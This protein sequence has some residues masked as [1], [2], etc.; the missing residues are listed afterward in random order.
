[1][2]A[3]L[4]S[5][6]ELINELDFLLGN[7][8]RL[9][10]AERGFLVSCSKFLDR[11]YRVNKYMMAVRPNLYPKQQKFL[12]LSDLEVY[13]GGSTGGGKS[14]S[15][16]LASLQFADVPTYSAVVLRST[17]KNLNR[18]GSIMDRCRDWLRD[19]DAHWDGNDYRFT[20]PSGAK[21]GFAYMES[22]KHADQHRSAEYQYCVER[23]SLVQMADGSLSPIESIAVGDMVRTL[24]GPQRV[25]HTFGPMVK[26]CVAVSDH[27]GSVVQVQ[28][29]SHR[30]LCDGGGWTSYLDS[31]DFAPDQPD[32]SSPTQCRAV[33]AVSSQTSRSCAETSRTRGTQ[34]QDQPQ[35]RESFGEPR[36]HSD[37]TVLAACGGDA[38]SVSVASRGSRQ[39]PPPQAESSPTPSRSSEHC[40]SPSVSCGR[41]LSRGA[42]CV[43]NSSSLAGCQEDCSADSCL[44]GEQPHRIAGSDRGQ[45]QQPVDVAKRTLT[46]LP[47]DA[48]GDVPAHSQSRSSVYAHPYTMVG[49]LAC[50]DVAAYPFELTPCGDREV[51]DIRV[52][53][54]SHYITECG[55]VNSNCGFDEVTEIPEECYRF[56]FSRMRRVKGGPGIPLRVRCASNPGGAHAAWVKSRFIPD[57]YLA[58]KD[59]DYRFGRM[60]EKS[61]PCVDCAGEGRTNGEPCL[62]C[63]GEGKQS[64]LFLP[65]RMQDNPSLDADDYRKALSRMTFVERMQAEHG[66]WDITAEGGVFRMAWL[67]YYSIQ[68]EYLRL[69]RFDEHNRPLP[70]VIVSRRE[71]MVFVTA[72]TAT[73][74]KTSADYSVIATWLFHRATGSLALLDV[75]RKKVDTPDLLPLLSG[76]CLQAKA[77]FVL[78]EEA[79]SGT[80]LIQLLRKNNACIGGIPVKSYLTGSLDKVARSAPAQLRM[81]SGM[82]YFP[83]FETAWKAEC[84]AELLSFPKSINDDFVDNVSMAAWYAENHNSIHIGG[85]N[86]SNLPSEIGSGPL[87]SFTRSSLDQY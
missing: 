57:E 2:P 38:Q 8:D 48:Q 69:T 81:E 10:D 84:V 51:F 5:S 25:T 50:V 82:I 17:F 78:I 77:K 15:L 22:L 74:A 66:D 76:A 70:D 83:A 37:R 29:E 58:C 18:S 86:A 33:Q 39:E 47:L 73:K 26:P 31:C 30:L 21:I 41:P 35:H 44:C 79:S 87:L 80:E 32:S 45:S 4:E 71:A 62:Y 20:F 36:G 13:T 43:R 46:C 9:T 23:G 72:D 67:R 59:N 63:D 1:M 64:R 14:D 24:E 55:L 60:W 28:G 3:P 61:D 54:S 19:S 34:Q 16:L 85:S 27:S 7:W 12:G 56:L 75:I 40:P 53:H 42:S 6:P 11:G 68:G 49:R 65:S 52:E